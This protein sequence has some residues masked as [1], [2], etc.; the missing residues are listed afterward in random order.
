MWNVTCDKP[1]G[2]EAVR[3]P[4]RLDKGDLQLRGHLAGVS[5]AMFLMAQ[6]MIFLFYPLSVV[7]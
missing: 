2:F 5:A 7:A 4:Q 6:T 3:S 1:G